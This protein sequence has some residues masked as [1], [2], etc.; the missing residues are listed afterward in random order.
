MQHKLANVMDAVERVGLSTTLEKSLLDLEKR[1][2]ALL[3]DAALAVGEDT[4][5][6]VPPPATADMYRAK[7]ATLIDALT[8]KEF[9]LR[10]AMSS[11]R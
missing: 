6:Q 4:V 5:V 2:A 11:N 10:L 9:R 7:V 1:Q 8:D 3:S